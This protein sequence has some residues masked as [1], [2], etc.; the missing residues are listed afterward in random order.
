[1]YRVH[2]VTYLRKP[3]HR[4][5]EKEWVEANPH[6]VLTEASPCG[7]HLLAEVCHRLVKGG[8]GVV[9]WGEV[10]NETPPLLPA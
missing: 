3:F 5:L 10:Y 4:V 7:D 1:M 6:L 8:R 2:S 9:G